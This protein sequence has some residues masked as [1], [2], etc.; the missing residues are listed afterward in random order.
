M[1]SREYQPQQEL[2]EQLL[3]PQ[4][5]VIGIEGGPCS[6]KTTLVEQLAARAATSDRPLV[7][8][9]E[10]ATQHIAKLETAGL[11][12]ADLAARD[13]EGFVA[14]ETD[15]LRTIIQ[16]IGAAKERYG[17]TDAIIVADRVDIGAYLTDAEH[18][19]V[20]TSLG[21][22]MPPM[23]SMVDQ[24][25]YLPTVARESITRYDELKATN[26]ARY[27]TGKQAIATCEANLQAVARH[28]ELHVLWGGDF[29]EKIAGAT[30]AIFEP[31]AE[32][33]LKQ[34]WKDAG[35]IMREVAMAERKRLMLGMSR[36]E[37]SYH[38]CDGRELRLR[39]LTTEQGETL[40]YLT[41][42]TGSGLKR[43]EV[44]RNISAETFGA[45]KA[46][47]QLGRMLHKLRYN[48]LKKD[49]DSTQSVRQ[50]TAD[51]YC[52]PHLQRWEVE[53]SVHDEQEAASLWPYGL[54]T[55]TTP[56]QPADYT[57]RQLAEL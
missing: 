23:L 44:Q 3:A 19:R 14:F 6:G 12:V 51:F 13:R 38:E 8:L 26:R 37:Q 29:T 5:T 9:P 55:P 21:L 50:W 16:Q 22:D 18:R 35:M 34:S 52:D 41:V 56:W 17:G 32:T 30:E 2:L 43:H 27:E 46:L 10:A 7:V 48:F 42:K 31:E 4:P 24:L 45:L 36:I 39:R 25:Y 1:I 20:L 57:A 11:S 28:P 15:V 54:Y 40:R 33:E 49:F 47:P 53:I